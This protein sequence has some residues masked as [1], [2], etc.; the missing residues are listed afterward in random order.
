VIVG[1]V[2]MVVSCLLWGVRVWGVGGEVEV[3]DSPRD[4]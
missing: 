2:T 4:N 3:Q 1:G